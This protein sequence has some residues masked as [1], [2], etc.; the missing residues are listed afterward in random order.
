M[1]DEKKHAIL[2]PSGADR[3]MTCPGSVTL[4]KGMPDNGSADASEG[5][6]LH[7]V[8]ALCL[9]SETN[10]EECIGQEMLSGAVLTEEQAADVQKYIDTV[11]TY[12][13]AT[14]NAALRIE[15]G[16][17]L[18]SMTGEVDGEGTADALIIGTGDEMV[19][20]DAKFG[21]GVDVP[22]EENRQLM[23]YAIGALD[24]H[25]L[26]DIVKKV[27][28]VISQ[29]RLYDKPK[30]WITTVDQ[31]KAFKDEVMEAACRVESHPTTYVPSDKA[32]KFCKAKSK[33]PALSN[34]VSDIN[35]NGFDGGEESA[36]EVLAKEGG[37]ITIE[38]DKLGELMTRIP[39]IESWIKSIRAEVERRLLA[40]ED[41]RGWKLVQ[42]KKGN[43]EWADEDLTERLLKK[44]KVKE[45]DMYTKKLVSVA[46]AEKK[47]AKK[48]PEVWALISE[49]GRITQA[50]GPKSVAPEHDPR[51]AIK[52]TALDEGF[53]DSCEDLL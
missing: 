14:P 28:L 53:E 9:E 46:A 4:S 24:K 23:M 45:T 44:A 20:I 12:R 13:D 41:V 27:Y 11:R 6:D 19:L 22:V 51:P 18:T 52:M 26:W 33:C 1:S 30:E 37:Q 3:W 5:T 43:R 48:N 36:D 49:Q 47:F 31:L 10:A 39:L 16:V 40:G 42:G 15:E 29:P 8:G 35:L 25:E 50:P 17:P 38:N 2:S 21:R 34:M 32:C 7:E